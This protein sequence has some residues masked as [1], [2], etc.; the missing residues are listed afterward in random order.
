MHRSSFHLP[1][2]PPESPS[3]SGIPAKLDGSYWQYSASRP[4]PTSLVQAQHQPAYPH[5]FSYASTVDRGRP[6][7]RT[8]ETNG[9]PAQYSSRSTEEVRP[10]RPHENP[11]VSLECSSSTV[12]RAIR[13]SLVHVRRF[14]AFESLTSYSAISCAREGSPYWRPI[15]P[16]CRWNRTGRGGLGRRRR[17]AAHRGATL[18]AEEKDEALPVSKTQRRVSTYL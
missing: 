5:Q 6:L 12:V 7:L 15:K 8:V 1:L 10:Q 11:L 17:C 2:S 14:S 13:N 3:M 18:A 16:G 4:P 9:H